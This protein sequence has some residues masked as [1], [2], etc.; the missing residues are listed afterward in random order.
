M[1]SLLRL[2]AFYL[3]I[4]GFGF[5]LI[6]LGGKQTHLPAGQKTQTEF[7]DVSGLFEERLIRH[8]AG[9]ADEDRA[10]SAALARYRAA[11]DAEDMTPFESFLAQ[12][13]DSAWSGALWT[14]LGL[15]YY[16]QGRYGRALSAW[17]RGWQ[18]LKSAPTG[19]VRALADRAL[20]E[21]CYMYARLGCKEQLQQLLAEIEGRSLVGSATEKVTG[22]RE[23]LWFM[24]HEP[25][26]SFLCGPYA[27]VELHRQ[28]R[29]GKSVPQSIATLRSTARGTSLLQLQQAAQAGGLRVQSIALGAKGAIPVPSIVHW[30]VGHFAAIT[31]K[32]NGR[33]RLQDPTFGDTHW[34]RE[35][36]L[37][38]ET[39]GY[40]LTAAGS[41]K[42]GWRIAED[43]VAAQIFGKGQTSSSD[44][45]DTGD[46]GKQ[47]HDD[48]DGDD[49]DDD[50]DDKDDKCKGMA[51][52]DIHLLVVSLNVEDM[53]LS[54]AP[55]VGPA[56]HLKLSYSHREQNLNYLSRH[57]NFGPKW[58]CRWLSILRASTSNPEADI[59]V[60][61][62]G[63]GLE[64]YPWNP[65]TL[66]FTPHS[67]SR[68]RI[69]RVSADPPV[70]E[71][72]LPNGSKEV[73]AQAGWSSGG[74]R[75]LLL[76]QIVDPQGNALTLGYDYSSGTRL[77]TVTDAIGQVTTLNYQHTDP[78][79]VTSVVDPF[80]R[81]ATLEYVRNR[82]G[83]WQLGAITD[84][85]GIV[86][87]FRYQN[88][89]YSDAMSDMETPY[90]ITTFRT[91]HGSKPERWL[92]ATTP[93]GRKERVEFRH[94]APLF[95][96]T[97]FHD[98]ADLVPVVAGVAFYNIY[99]DKRNTFY[100]DK[101]AY[102]DAFPSG[103][104]AVNSNGFVADAA[105]YA[106]ARIFHWLHAPNS[107]TAG[108]LESYKDPLT[109]RIWFRY[110]NQPSSPILNNPPT[111][112]GLEM[113]EQ[114]TI[115]AVVMPDGTT[116]VRRADYNST[117]GNPTRTIDPIGRT[118]EYEYSPDGM[119]LIGIRRVRGTRRDLL[120]RISYNTTHQPLIYRDAAGG[121]TRY[122]YNTRGQLLQIVN[123]RGETTRYEYD[124]NGYLRA[125]FSPVPGDITRF[126]YD[127]KGRVQTVADGLGR[128]VTS[129][130]DNLDRVTRQ[131]FPDGTFRAYGYTLLDLT[132]VRDRQGR[133]TQM[134]YNEGRELTVIVDPA[135]RRTQLE[136]CGCG[137]VKTLIDGEARTTRW[138]YDTQGRVTGK[139]FAD[140]TQVDYAYDPV[141]RLLTRRDAEGQTAT[142]EYYPDDR[143]K[144]IHYTGARIP[145]P[146]VTF[147]YDD[148]GRVTVMAD[149]SGTTRYTYHPTGAAGALQIAEVDGPLAD[150]LVRYRYDG[151][152]RATHRLFG[153][154]QSVEPKSVQEQIQYDQFGRVS[155]TTNPLGTF[156]YGY[157][158]NSGLPASVEAFAAPT[159]RVLQ[160]TF[161]YHS[162]QNDFRLASIVTSGANGVALNY[163]YNS[164]GEVLS[165]AGGVGK[166]Q[167]GIWQPGRVDYG[168]NPASELT[169]ATL[170]NTA[171]NAILSAAFYD[172]DRA[173]NRT[174]E[175]VD[176]VSSSY[177]LTATN[178]LQ[179]GTTPQGN[180]AF[181]HDRNGN[182]TQGLGG[183]RYE[184]DAENRL[185]AMVRGN[186]RTEF[187][188][189]GMSRWVGITEKRD[190]VAV[191]ARR[192]LW[193]GMQLCAERDEQGRT[194]RFFTNGFQD[195][196]GARYLYVRDRLGSVIR[197]LDANTGNL[198][199]AYQYDA[200]GRRTVLSQQAGVECPIGFTGHYTHLSSGLVLAPFRAYDPNLGRW[201]NRDPIEEGGGANLYEYSYSTPG[202]LIDLS[203]LNP[204]GYGPVGPNGQPVGLPENGIPWYW[205]PD[206]SNG[207]G[208][209][210]KQPGNK[211]SASWDDN[212][213]E[214]GNC[215][216]G[217]PHWDVDDGTGRRN[218]RRYRADGTPITPEEAHGTPVPTPNATPA[219]QQ[220]PLPLMPVE[221][222][223]IPP[224]KI[225]ELPFR[226]PPFRIPIPIP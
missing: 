85:I 29:P 200:W 11:R 16:D 15:V 82:A 122:T 211:N 84:P 86:S 152:G 215:K 64:T 155:A 208:G 21:L 116:Q 168:Y 124:A 59:T 144:A 224:L 33:Y 135:G 45:N 187:L 172:F 199:A 34:I 154:A 121:Q 153:A 204:S 189:D 115:T 71:R 25:E 207:R 184:W 80:G 190:G 14:N 216:P 183:V 74:Y 132:S 81:R 97:N 12:H 99:L 73:Y 191:G 111:N 197:L 146:S 96:V 62:R 41:K 225:P 143:L 1:R 210:W 219:P 109:R 166:I 40:F 126:T 92:E 100:W 61:K 88:P 178:A 196:S 203:G 201:L 31:T 133:L 4:L 42:P 148:Y 131:D 47:A 206:N 50:D 38:E 147:T 87:S 13:P 27:L 136:W 106:K 54:Y 7:P 10:L 181:L 70:Y 218:R 193:S 26:T 104:A 22:A 149:G 68:A 66:D 221:P 186:E 39:S 49:D 113:L 76:T 3:A 75:F 130:Y 9:D 140:S 53:P 138:N 51:Q 108:V 72:R 170:R 46:D 2:S 198:V 77:R 123:P 182:M 195:F 157:V 83:I 48:G 177:I 169:A 185:S 35:A 160:T 213:D 120:A 94:S 137:R 52:Y 91:G 17:Q 44:G 57:F 20:G 209:T 161:G 105:P 118:L 167:N 164:E 102:S 103:T 139:I 8:G 107:S 79:K 19:D 43:S 150:D 214:A 60:F 145:T 220:S 101:R 36:D 222:V 127:D 223:P 69:V 56:V 165:Y 173:G 18:K 159:R 151:A 202:N 24:Q 226:I 156:R 110:P 63:G 162:A 23:G 192:F 119:D 194:R 129:T 30:K 37:R 6:S 58:T 179:N 89:E 112:Y 78:R 175:A 95:P 114:P 180:W 28:I 55:P 205:S 98:P 65:N 90:G 158:P 171:S 134:T 141:G 67:R 174:L 212:L 5:C 217:Q 188:Y 117:W 93:Q 125:V 128:T 163:T 176:G 32:R 142:Y